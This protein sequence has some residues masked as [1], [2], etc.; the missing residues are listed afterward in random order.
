MSRALNPLYLKADSL[1]WALA[2]I[3][4]FGDTDLFPVPFEF[5]A[6]RAVWPQVRDFLSQLDVANTE[7][8]ANWKM[9][10]PKHTSGFRGA[11]QLAPFDSLVYAA[12][13]SESAQQIEKFR[14]PI[15]EHVACAYRLEISQDGNFFRKDTGWSDFHEASER[16]SASATCTHVVCADIS[17]FY[18]QISHHRIQ[19]ALEQAGIDENRT[20]VIERFLSNINAKHHSRG[21]P[22]GPAVSILLAEACLADVDNFVRQRYAHTRYVDDFRIFCS[23][24]T[25]ALLALHDLSEFLHTAHRLS[26]QAGK[27][28]ILESEKFRK[29]ELSDPEIEERKAKEAGVIERIKKLREEN[30]ADWIDLDEDEIKEQEIQIGREVLQEMMRRVIESASLPLGSARH[31]LRRAMTIRSRSILEELLANLEKFV[32]VI[33]EVV[34][35]L[36]KVHTAKNNQRIGEHLTRLLS[37]SPYGALPFVQYWILTAIHN[38]PQFVDENVA[39][40]LAEQSH[41]TIRDRM[42]A[43]IAAAYGRSEWVRWKKETWADTSAFAQ[44][45]IIWSSRVL[46]RNERNHWIQP[47]RNN[48][49]PAVRLFADGVFV[50]NAQLP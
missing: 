46:P 49:D 44:R 39:V 29:A 6:Y 19:G 25:E 4:R 35:Y 1:D 45:A 22:V 3:R 31:V 47:I 17:D 38:V 20:H 12:L 34:L 14:R 15:E 11:T 18:N 28:M 10:V 40:M 23:S 42:S 7:V 8:A 48:L 5:E 37:D 9:M 32:P 43:L 24:R 16:L 26:L 36:V 50:S 41:S 27:T 2:H 21:I 30:Y 13:V 33:R